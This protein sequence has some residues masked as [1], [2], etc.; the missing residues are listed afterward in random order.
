MDGSCRRPYALWQVVDMD[1]DMRT[2]GDGLG[3]TYR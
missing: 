3:E 2:W 1:M